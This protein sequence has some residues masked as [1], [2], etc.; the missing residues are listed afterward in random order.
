MKKLL[1]ATGILYIVY[2][3][4]EILFE[5]TSHLMG[6]GEFYLLLYLPTKLCFIAALSLTLL[7]VR[8]LIKKKNTESIFDKA[9]IVLL[10]LLIAFYTIQFVILAPLGI[11]AG[12][13]IL[14]LEP[15]PLGGNIYFTYPYGLE[16][17]F[18]M[19]I[20]ELLAFTGIYRIVNVIEKKKSSRIILLQGWNKAIFFTLFVILSYSIPL[21]INGSTLPRSIIHITSNA[22]Y[23]TISTIT[24]IILGVYLILRKKKTK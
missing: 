9:T 13:Y 17:F 3:L 19:I 24:S 11:L 5:F 23:L 18:P 21:E 20:I 15:M 12:S 8:K 1:L 6:G 10:S 4:L 22:I 7:I 14:F 16:T 2:P